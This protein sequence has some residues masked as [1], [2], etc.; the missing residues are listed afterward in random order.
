MHP[1]T[2]PLPSPPLPF[3]PFPVITPIQKSKAADFTQGRST[4]ASQTFHLPASFSR[5]RVSMTNTIESVCTTTRLGTADA[6]VA[7][8]GGCGYGL[9]YKRTRSSHFRT[10]TLPYRSNTCSNGRE[11]TARTAAPGLD[12]R[13]DAAIQ[14]SSRKGLLIKYGVDVLCVPR[15]AVFWLSWSFAWVSSSVFAAVV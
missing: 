15:E 12:C 3:S 8:E 6:W 10:N 14:G 4:P 11:I 9:F 1:P 5:S 7:G 13:V 2:Q